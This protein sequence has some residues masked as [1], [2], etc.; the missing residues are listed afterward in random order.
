MSN[1]QDANPTANVVARWVPSCKASLNDVVNRRKSVA[2]E[3]NR[4]IFYFIL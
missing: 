1:F 3:E 4:K 2:N